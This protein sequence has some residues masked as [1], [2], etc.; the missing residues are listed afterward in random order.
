MIH[1]LRTYTFQPGKLPEYLKI[2]EEVGRPIRGNDYGI[3]RGYWTSEFGTINQI[4]HLWEYE[5]HAERDDL[6]AKLAKNEDWRT[7]YGAKIR[8]LIQRQDI[9][10]MDPVVPFKAPEGEGHIYEFRYYRTKVGSAPIWLGHY[11]DV[12]PAREKYSPNVGVWHTQA[13][14][15]NEVCHMWVY[16]DLVQRSKVRAEMS[17]DPAWKD[18]LSKGTQHLLEMNTIALIPTNYSPLK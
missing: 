8:P 15:P 17:Q 5:S 13:P 18:F 14:Q 10:F 4:W 1:E 11:K 7:Q 16:D 12:L 9:R 6:R 2:A 3:N